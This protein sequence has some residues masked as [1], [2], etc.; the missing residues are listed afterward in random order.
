M[1]FFT[2]LA[3]VATLLAA[4]GCGD[5]SGPDG[6]TLA[7]TYTL[8]TVNGSDLPFTLLQVGTELKV[9]VISDVVTLTANNTFS[10]VFT[11][12]ETENGVVTNDTT[13]TTGTFTVT[14]SLVQMTDTEGNTLTA[15]FSGGN[16]LT[17]TAEGF[18][19]VYRK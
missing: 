2:R 1:R 12:R 10:E 7:G 11:T 9:E 15:S 4:S 6:G 17:A 14:G 13:T 16:T 3:L 8:R 18:T 19:L 5:T